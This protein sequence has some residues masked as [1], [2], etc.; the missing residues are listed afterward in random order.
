MRTLSLYD[1]ITTLLSATRPGIYEHLERCLSAA[2]WI[3]S[4]AECAC[5]FCGGRTIN[6]SLSWSYI[7]SVCYKFR[8]NAFISFF[9]VSC[10]QNWLQTDRHTDRHTDAAEYFISD[11]INLTLTLTRSQDFSQSSPAELD[12]W[13]LNSWPFS[14]ITL[15]WLITT[16]VIN[17]SP[18]VHRHT[19]G[20]Q[21]NY[22]F[23]E[24]LMTFDLDLWPWQQLMATRKVCAR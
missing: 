5:T 7:G 14:V 3:D 22:V 8:Q 23:D 1:L 9:E 13:P 19:D 16:C 11:L 24:F 4:A 18:A 15:M 10:L 17:I 2:M 21:A 20:H 6:E 12:L